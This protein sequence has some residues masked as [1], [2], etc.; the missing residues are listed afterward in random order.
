[1]CRGGP[2]PSTLVYRH[3]PNEPPVCSWVA[4]ISAVSA[5]PPRGPD[6][7][8]AWLGSTTN[9][10]FSWATTVD[11]AASMMSTRARQVSGNRHRVAD[12]DQRPGMATR[13]EIMAVLLGKHGVRAQDVS[14]GL[15]P[16]C[17]RNCSRCSL[18]FLYSWEILCSGF[19]P[20]SWHLTI[21]V[22][23]PRDH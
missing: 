17:A 1:M 6:K 21:R 19:P 9:P 16:A 10:C 23:R 5:S 13:L 14:T 18:L 15:C 7:R 20:P 11:H 8:G 4:R 22:E 2:P 3:T 12:T